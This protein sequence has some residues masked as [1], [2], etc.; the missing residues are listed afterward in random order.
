MR[1][2]KSGNNTNICKHRALKP[3]VKRR[4]LFPAVLLLLPVLCVP[5]LNAQATSDKD[6]QKQLE[7]KLKGA[8]VIL[9]HFYSGN[10]LI[11][12]SEGTLVSGGKPGS[13][14]TSAYFEPEKIKVSKK[15]ITLLG[16]RLCWIYDDSENT[17]VFFRYPDNTKIEISR[18]P[19][20]KNLPEIMASMSIVFLK[21][22]E[23]LADFV[24]PYWRKIIQADFETARRY[25]ANWE[26]IVKRIQMESPA[27]P[28]E[29]PI[30]PPLYL[31]ERRKFSRMQ[32]LLRP[33]SPRIQ[34]WS[35]TDFTEEARKFRVSGRIVFTANIDEDG[36]PRIVDIIK[37]LGAGLDDNAVRVI[38][39]TW[40]FSPATRDGVPFVFEN[41]TIDASF[42]LY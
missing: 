17:P 33:D 19:E 23:P 22:E 13:W 18:L 26:A 20:Q 39:K 10:N 15:S 21:S 34:S 11:Y 4:L 32:S 9:R 40:K 29:S 14:T 38:E 37:P 2:Q 8:T 1:I 31:E 36:T 3:G 25:V 27:Q 35:Q 6:I 24:P 5:L 7:T 12:N 28:L 42:Y 30:S 16:K 41:A